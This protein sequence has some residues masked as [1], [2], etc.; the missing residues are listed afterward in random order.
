M[1]ASLADTGYGNSQTSRLYR[2]PLNE[3]LKVPGGFRSNTRLLKQHSFE[4]VKLSREEIPMQQLPVRIYRTEKQIVLAAPL[5]GL[6]PE[7]IR[8][9]I[10]HKSMKIDANLR[11]P[12]Q[13]R[14]DV[15]QA[16]W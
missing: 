11:G 16:E 9:T 15:L 4:K 2:L 5:A 6:E 13:D 10:D 8:I 1:G 3:V 7:D 14:P 12:G